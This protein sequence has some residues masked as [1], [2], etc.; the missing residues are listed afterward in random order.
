MKDLKSSLIFMIDS[1]AEVSAIPRPIDW[2]ARPVN[3]V[4]TAANQLPINVF[5]MKE[6][7]IEFIKGKPIKWK[8]VVGVV[9]HPL[10]GGDTLSFFHLLPD[11]TC[12]RLVHASLT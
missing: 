3:F 5:G 7:N 12:K 1:G 6:L 4:L 9:P 2:V 8:F 10:V 11:L